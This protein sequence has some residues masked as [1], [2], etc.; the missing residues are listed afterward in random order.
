MGLWWRVRA[1]IRWVTRLVVVLFKVI[2]FLSFVGVAFWLQSGWG[3]SIRQVV[4]WVGELKGPLVELV[5]AA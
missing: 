1:Y 5:V 2:G 4:K 3:S